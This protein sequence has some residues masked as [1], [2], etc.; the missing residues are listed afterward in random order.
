MSYLN[1]ALTII[2]GAVLVS[3]LFVAFVAVV[4]SILEY[5]DDK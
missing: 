2:V 5:D 4:Q 1:T 3:G